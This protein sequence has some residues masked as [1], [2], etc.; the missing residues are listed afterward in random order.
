VLASERGHSPA[1]PFIASLTL[2]PMLVTIILLCME[3]TRTALC[4][5]GPRE[6][7]NLTG[8]IDVRCRGQTLQ[9]GDAGCWPLGIA[10]A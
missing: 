4:Q 10:F 2:S 8:T 1:G 3:K 7:A 6:M 5:I 9:V